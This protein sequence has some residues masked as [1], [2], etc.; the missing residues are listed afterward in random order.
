MNDWMKSQHIKPIMKT[1]NDC[2]ITR[3]PNE[4]MY[5]FSKRLAYMKILTLIATKT[6]MRTST[7]NTETEATK[8]RDTIRVVRTEYENSLAHWSLN[9]CHTQAFS[10]SSVTTFEPFQPRTHPSTTTS[11]PW[12]ATWR[13]LLVSILPSK[14]LSSSGESTLWSETIQKFL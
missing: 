4:W 2:A 11:S 10:R 9:S 12:G 8:L 3:T 14:C 1:P 13:L 5:E 7:A 6:T